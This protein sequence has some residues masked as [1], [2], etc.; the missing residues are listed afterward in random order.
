MNKSRVLM[1]ALVAVVCLTAWCFTGAQALAA[2]AANARPAYITFTT[3]DQIWYNDALVVSLVPDKAQCEKAYGKRWREMCAVAPGQSGSVP[4]GVSLTPALEGEWRWTSST[5][6]RFVPKRAW[7]AGVRYTLS[8]AKLPLPPRAQLNRKSSTFDMWPLSALTSKGQFWVDPH[9]QGERAASF[10]VRFSTV[11]DKAIIERDVQVQGS[12]GMRLGKPQFV[13]SD[14]DSRCLIKAPIVQMPSQPGSLQLTIRGVKRLTHGDNNNITYTPSLEAGGTLG[15]PAGQSLLTVKGSFDSATGAS[16]GEEYVLTLESSLLVRPDEVLK[17]IKAVELPLKNSNEALRDYAWANAPRISP[18]DIAKGRPLTLEALQTP[19]A[20]ATK[21]RFRVPVAAGHYV[22]FRLPRGFFPSATGGAGAGGGLSRDWQAVYLAGKPEPSVGFLQSGNVLRLGAGAALDVVGTGLKAIKWR[23]ETVLPAFLGN[24]AN[25]SYFYGNE[26]YR[27]VDGM[28]VAAEGEIALTP[29][30]DPLAAQ[31]ASLDL[32]K[33][34][35]DTRGLVRMTLT[36]VPAGTQADG[37]PLPEVRT[38]RMLQLTPWGVLV[39]EAADGSRDV[40]VC[41]LNSGAAVPNVTVQVLGY[42]GLGVSKSTTGTDGRARV[43]PLHGLT[44][45]RQPVAV[46]VFDQGGGG[47]P[48]AWLSLRD[49]ALQ[50]KYSRFAVGGMHSHADGVNAYVFSQRGMFRPGETLHFGAVVRRG[51]W[52]ALPADLPLKVRVYDPSEARI[53]EKSATLSRC[54]LLAFDCPTAETAPTGR[55]RAEVL[56]GDTLLGSAVVRVEEFQPDTMALNV[57]LPRQLGNGWLYVPPQGA[58]PAEL[59]V[60]L[61]NLHGTAAT[62]RRVSGQMSAQPMPLQP[63]GYDEY[64]FYDA[65]VQGDGV[66]V[67]RNLPDATTDAEGKAVLP[68]PLDEM[69]GSMQVSVL[70]EGFEASGGRAVSQRRNFWVSRLPQVMGYKPNGPGVNLNFVP[71]GVDTSIDFVTLDPALHMVNPGQLSFSVAERRYINALT[72]DAQGRYTYEETPVDTVVQENSIT[73]KDDGTCTWQVPTKAPGDY[74]L[75]VRNGAGVIMARVPFVIAGNDDLRPLRAEELPS[76]TLRVRTDK[77]DYEQ[78]AAVQMMLS[79]PY[80][81]L[82]FI[83]L[84]RDRVFAHHFVPVKAGNSVHTL[85]LPQDFEGRGYVNVSLVRSKDAPEIFMQP[86]AAAV[87]PITVNVARRDLG[88]KVETP[89]LLVPGETLVARVSAR[90][91]GDAV[92]FA[93]DEGVL[94][95]TRFATPKP[96]HYLLVDRALEVRTR[97]M[98][99]LLMPEH[100]LLAQRLSAFG[101]GMD[102]LGGRFHNPFKRRTEPPLAWWSAV[103]QVGPQGTEVRVP[104]PAWY[105]G[106]VRVMAV[107]ASAMLAGNAEANSLVRGNVTLTPQLPL[108]VAPGDSFAGGVLVSNN[109]DKE[110]PLEVTCSADAPLAL[111]GEATRK[112]TLAPS[113]EQ[114]VPLSFTAGALPGAALAHFAARGNGVDVKRDTGISVRPATLWRQSML[115]G[116]IQGAAD[117]TQATTASNV[118]L[119]QRRALLPL[120]DA[121]KDA[122]ASVED[123]PLQ[124]ETSFSLAAVPLPAVRALVR[125]LR[126]YPYG[127][128][129]QLLSRAMAVAALKNAPGILA[130]IDGAPDSPHARTMQER[131]QRTVAMA[132]RAVAAALHDNTLRA[133][134]DGNYDGSGPQAATDTLLRTAYGADVLFALK[135]AGYT[136]P[137]DTLDSML[138]GLDTGCSTTPVNLGQAR[139]QAYAIWMLT[140]SGRITA[141]IIERLIPDFDGCGAWREDVTGLFIA[142]SYALMRMDNEAQSLAASYVLPDANFVPYGAVDALAAQSLAVAVLARHFPTML[143]DK[144]DDLGE[145]MTELCNQGM[146]STFSAALGTRALL[147]LAARQE[148]VPLTGVALQCVG[149]HQGFATPPADKAQVVWDEQTQGILSLNVPGCARVQVVAPVDMALPTV[150]YEISAAGYDAKPVRTQA[151]QGAEVNRVWLNAAGEPVQKVKQGDVVTVQLSAKL[152]GN[153][154]QDVVLCDL[155]PGGCELV[156]DSE[157]DKAD[158]GSMRMERREDRVLFFTNLGAQPQEAS[159]KMRVTAKGVF[160][161]PAAQLEA[162]YAPDIFANTAEGKLTVE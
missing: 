44:R 46:V 86:H 129:E 104:V 75:T 5:T 69:G 147:A 7:G 150:Y 137:G 131:D 113:S 24:L 114:L 94:Q 66:K 161:L 160:A 53:L 22:L 39:K 92:I 57:T 80:D 23:A 43:A 52:Q 68:L 18:E 42:N 58:E 89:Q 96:L 95:L 37:S 74:L 159:Y 45:E 109:T 30:K 133:W 31:Y 36:G 140:R 155:L 158:A 102:M 116:R 130:A 21:L 76:S 98:F 128:T 10:D 81:G 48:M 142:A 54:G 88:L 32:G 60:Q 156:L 141:P 4:S 47:T 40:F 106:K 55:Y 15:I 14:N 79:A 139:A 71:Q 99:G 6:M 49:D 126:G 110:L 120:V 100:S 17:A 1:S 121:K 134:P 20:P 67:E 153:A 115:A 125:Q 132:L 127:C 90:E 119:L 123:A 136:L 56:S 70:V 122:A 143:A 25:E 13:W 62:N 28:S 65:A 149:M 3:N 111:Q 77:A 101:G 118:V 61:R 146:P 82:A 97:H 33:L 103:V 26:D 154:T 11:P 152:Y 157:N 108:Q 50:E 38:S 148:D 8:L 105:S 85:N 93:V 59:A 151:R 35:A 83:T 144:V 73:P 124:A 107:G 29:G 145:R 2:A 51:D 12:Q 78:G 19:T 117:A 16:L 135:D 91:A 63:A 9:P 27:D 72:T 34:G 87:A 64:T 162:M 112:L 138:D 84:E 41:D